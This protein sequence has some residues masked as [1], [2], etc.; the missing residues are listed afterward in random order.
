MYMCKNDVLREHLLGAVCI[1]A[2][3]TTVDSTT[4]RPKAA[5]RSGT[6]GI[7]ARDTAT[8]KYNYCLLSYPPQPFVPTRPNSG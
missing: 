5:D 4:S 6:M 2:L 1:S 3:A 7:A 8:R